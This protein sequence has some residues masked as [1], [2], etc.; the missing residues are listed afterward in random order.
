MTSSSAAAQSPKAR[1]YRKSPTLHA[2]K[3]WENLWGK[4]PS[5]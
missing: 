5:I 3:P 1:I 4:C 2:S